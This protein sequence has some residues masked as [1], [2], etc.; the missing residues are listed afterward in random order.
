MDIAP[1]KSKINDE[2]WKWRHNLKIG[3]VIDCIENRIW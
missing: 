3:D 2:E 1:Y